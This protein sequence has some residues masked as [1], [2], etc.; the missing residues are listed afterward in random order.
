MGYQ[1]ANRGGKY[2]H[3]DG[4]NTSAHTCRKEHISTHTCRVGN[5]TSAHTRAG[6][7][8]HISTH[9]C[10]TGHLSTH[11][12]RI[13]HIST[14]TCRI[15]HVS[16]HTCRQGTYQHTHMP[17]RGISA[18][19]RAGR[20]HLSTHT[21]QEGTYQ[22]THT[23]WEGTYK[24][25]H[26]PGRN[27]S[28]HTHV[29]VRTHQYTRTRWSLSTLYFNNGFASFSTQFTAKLI[30]FVICLLYFRNDISLFCYLFVF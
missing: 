16:T 12:C 29:L 4:S 13:G 11:T 19:I 25:I 24:H 8:G 17:G 20:G 26:V 15:G 28:A 3:F 7:K 23:C 18:H 22:H 21:C 14:H 10:R 1:W 9:T 2:G 27:I 5:I 30:F 6:K